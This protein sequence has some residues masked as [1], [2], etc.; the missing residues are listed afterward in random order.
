M[1]GIIEEYGTFII[2]SIIALSIISAM[3]YAAV[4]QDGAIHMFVRM[5]M[6]NVGAR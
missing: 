2:G 1:K 5:M 3:I 6:E 4:A